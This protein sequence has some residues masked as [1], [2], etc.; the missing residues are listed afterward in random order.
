MLRIFQKGSGIVNKAK[1]KLTKSGVAG[2]AYHVDFKT[3]FK[4]L[5]DPN[6]WNIPSKE[7]EA[8][9]KKRVAPLKRS[10]DAV[11][12]LGFKGSYTSFA[13]KIGTVHKPAYTFPRFGSGIDIH[14]QIRKLSKPKA[15]WTLPGHEYT[16]PYNDLE[17]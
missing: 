3:G 2:S 10:Y 1:D 7:E 17:N 12:T 11:K 13:K 15:G 6:L 4:L 14:K 16:G 8:D 5:T 9:M